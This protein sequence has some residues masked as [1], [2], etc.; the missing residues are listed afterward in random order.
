M[1]IFTMIGTAI[2][3][4]LFAG[5][6]L[7][8]TLISGALAFGAK[9]A[10][11]YLNRPKKRNYSAVQG[12]TQFG[13]DVPVN[14]LFGVGKVRGQ[15]LFYAKYGSGNKY[16]AEVFALANGWCDGLEPYVYFYGEKRDLV[17]RAKIGG[18]AAHYG[19]DGYDNLI[20]IRFYDGRP[21][22]LADAKLVADTAALGQ[23][24]KSTSRCTGL[25]YVVIEREYDGDKFGKGRPDF[26][27][28]LRGLRE[29]DPRKDSTVA[30]G[31]GPQRLDDRSTYVFT[32]NPAVHRL[33]YQLGLRGLI[34][35]R[36][37][38]GEGKSLGQLDLGTYFVAMNVCDTVR[39]GKPTYE[40]GLWATAEDDHTE[41]L[42]EFDDAMAGYGLN[43]RG[44]SG[45]IPGAPQIPV[46]EIS[47]D[48]IPID[49]AQDVQRR[50]SAFDLFNHL[51][52]QFTSIESQWAPESLKPIYVNADVA[53]DGR[54]RQTTNDFLQVT[55]PDIAQYLLQIRYR[56][57]RKGGS[58]TVPVSRRVGLAVQEG[59]WVTFDGTD[60][61]ITGWQCDEQF[62]FTLTLAETSSDIYSDAGIEPGPI[63][64]PSPPPINP[65]LL[66]T[67][68]N[69]AVEVGMIAGSDGNEVPALRFTWTPPSDPTI[70]AVR[71][72]YFIG[73]DP[74]G[75]TIYL[76]QT[77]AAEAGVY[78]TSKDVQAG[79]YYTA[80]ATIT[81]TPDRFKTWTPWF[82]TVAATPPYSIY[83]PGMVAGIIAATDEMLEPLRATDLRQMYD[84]T[85]A[86]ALAAMMQDG[87][88]Y[89]DVQRSLTRL[90]SVYDN[91]TADYQS[92]V[93]VKTGPDSTIVRRLD[94]FDATIPGLATVSA[95]SATTAR[96]TNLEGTTTAY[97]GRLD[98]IE[99]ALPQKADGSALNSLSVTVTNQGNTLNSQGDAITGLQTTIAGKADASALNSLSTTVTNQGNTLSAQ[100][101]AI[102]GVQADVGK[103]SAGG[104]FRTKAVATESGAQSTIGI[105]ASASS[106]EGTTREAAILLSAIAGNKSMVGLVADLV[107]F[108]DNAGNKAYPFVFS[109][110]VARLENIVVGTLKFDQLYSNNNKLVLRGSGSLADLSVFV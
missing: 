72:E 62:R 95:L 22:Q 27:F 68:Q 89:S 94:T 59:E 35:G 17:A 90:Q 88:Q 65:S 8:A 25:T 84:D 87:G 28:V 98:L 91:V 74:A 78:V 2:A 55:D 93:E 32:K 49:R 75:Q 39:E 31:S 7:A 41:I 56:Q 70:T 23:T 40:C 86:N 60:W 63:V 14:A 52:G 16:N 83:L 9:L 42:K 77:A 108:T 13:G 54:P 51:S 73:N 61:L 24:W 106:G 46:L 64:I 30:G 1:P 11:S 33:N 26:D 15:R 21:G 71:F 67:V 3:G 44:L 110:G 29:Y 45:V 92:L 37:L 38:I 82:T 97:G 66:S 102:T 10:L 47:A 69:F 6:S 4:A 81:T 96:V 109:G 105:Y 107:Y 99:V 34:S 18:E 36:T 104:F 57:N 5:S 76:D 79:V 48:D 43:R 12:D 58:A 85:R 101:T 80:R 20:S 53:A 19:V 50:K 103:F 100:G